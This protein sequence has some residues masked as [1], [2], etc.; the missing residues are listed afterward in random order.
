MKLFD[1]FAVAD[2]VSYFEGHIENNISR[3]FKNI[4]NSQ[5]TQHQIVVERCS[6]E[7]RKGEQFPLGVKTMYKDYH[8]VR[9]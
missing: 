4:K 1:V 2:Y 8:S 9:W 7:E 6:N 3:L 5:W